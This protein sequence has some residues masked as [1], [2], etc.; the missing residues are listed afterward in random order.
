MAS[1]IWIVLNVLVLLIITT[2][3]T[4]GVGTAYPSGASEFT[5]GFIGVRSL[6]LDVFFVDRCLSP[7]SFFFLYFYSACS[8]KQQSAVDMSLHSDTLAL[9]FLL[10]AVCSTN[11]K[12]YFIDPMIYRTGGEHALTNTPRMRLAI[13]CRPRNKKYTVFFVFIL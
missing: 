4:C 11:Y 2:G 5:L 12:Y 9:L 1:F 3:V 6:V 13:L 8:L 7:W 10:N